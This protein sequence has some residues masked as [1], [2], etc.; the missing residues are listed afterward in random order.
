VIRSLVT[1]FFYL[2]IIFPAILI[3]SKVSLR[4]KLTQ[5]IILYFAAINFLGLRIIPYILIT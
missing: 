1:L 4:F 3:G 5:K 2:R